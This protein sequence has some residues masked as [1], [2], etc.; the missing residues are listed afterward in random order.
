VHLN[1]SGFYHLPS[2]SVSHSIR[3]KIHEEVDER[4]RKVTNSM[5]SR[6]DT[7]CYSAC[8]EGPRP[9]Q[10][11]LK[12]PRASPCHLTILAQRVKFVACFRLQVCSFRHQSASP[13]KDPPTSPP[14]DPPTLPPAPIDNLWEAQTRQHLTVWT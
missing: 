10:Q 6:G 7:C 11:H 13:P 5:T 2:I 3:N 14:E 1:Y 4:M 12:V 8:Q 9:D